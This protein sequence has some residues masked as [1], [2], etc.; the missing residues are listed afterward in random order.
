M[1][2]REYDDDDGRVVADM[3]DVERM[4]LVIPRID[5]DKGSGADMSR[6]SS[7]ASAQSSDQVTLD[8]E[9]RRAMIKGAVSAALLVGGVIAAAFAALIFLILQ[10]AG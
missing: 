7:S 4:P 9:E 2:K 8:N 5:R 1:G 3:S 6:Q 10:M